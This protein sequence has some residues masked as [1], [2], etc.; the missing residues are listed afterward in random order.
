MFKQMK[1]GVKI[2]IGFACLLVIAIALGMLAISKMS[3]VK[4]E[5]TILSNEYVPEVK[6][7]NEVERFSL[8]TMYNMRGYAY[9]EDKNYL[10][11][12]RKN[13]ADVKKSITD[14]KALAE[15]A[16]HLVKLKSAVVEVDANVAEY[17]SL[18]NQTVD[19]NK[20][21]E[22]NRKQMDE[23]A[24]AYMQNCNEF[25]KMQ[26]DTMSQ[27]V[28]SELSQI[29]ERVQ[30][31]NLVNDIVDLG[32][33]IRLSVWRS[34]AEQNNELARQALNQFQEIDKK[35][36][37]LRKVTTQQVNLDQI[38]KTQ[39][40]GATYAK[41]IEQ[42][43]A[44]G[45]TD[46]VKK[47]LDESAK[48]YMTNCSN[49]LASQNQALQEGLN[50]L[51]SKLTERLTKITTVNDIIDL[52]NIT[53][54]A[55]WRAQAQ[56][57]PQ[58][59]QNAQ[60]NF[61]EMDKKFQALRAITRQQVNLQEIDATRTAAQ[62]YKDAMNALLVNWMAA[63]ELSVK[64]L[65]AGEAV[66]A[67]SQEIAMAGIEQTTAIAQQ[68]VESLSSATRSL[69][70]GLSAAV[71]LG[72]LIAVFITRMIVKPLQMGVQF[73]ELVAEGD[74]TQTIELN[75]KDEIGVL[76]NALNAM[77]AN[78]HNVMNQIQQ[79]AEQVAASSEE[80]SA[81]SQNMANSATEQAANLEETSAAIHQLN[82]SIGQNKESASNTDGVS[83]KAAIEAEQGGVAVEK[84][85]QAMKQIADKISI[86]ND[87]ADQTNLLALNA[88]IEAA[89]AGEMGKGF[90]VVAVEVRKLA[91]RSQQAAKEI[92]ELANN[93]VATAEEAGNLIKRVVPSIKNATQLVQEISMRCMEQAESSEQIRKA[94]DQL[95]QAT[96]SNSATSEEC[97][98]A[99]E[100]LSAQAIA[101]QELVSQFKLRN[102]NGSKQATRQA[103]KS[104]SRLDYG[105]ISKS[106]AALP[107][108]I[109]RASEQD[110]SE[111]T[112]E[113]RHF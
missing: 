94:M 24:A 19:T 58:V 26:N 88:A 91:E 78:L 54:I 60:P 107:A 57:D 74:L 16:S 48:T 3:G 44:S 45:A 65:A 102:N 73:A 36:E 68:T 40:A 69:I 76:A 67:K 83:S 21:I 20:T 81:S 13:L 90:A 96:Q 98:S 43:L 41:A 63:Q 15:S 33:A 99:S 104:V 111:T 108:S 12:G 14:A 31:I 101:L 113:F 47:Q 62:S 56:R 30:K 22:E 92:I 51:K 110:E 59:I 109:H 86:I 11:L 105:Y 28:D 103:A 32:N 49:F 52:G 66:L 53:R 10:D 70:V 50:Q 35:F 82:A 23:S 37:A 64:R 100:E 42:L 87:I 18:S 5:A 93:S 106:T 77:S 25:L 55:A 27:E 2:G 9:T 75:Q 80:L 79:S 1:L 34:Q 29:L 17:E 112:D 61:D 4:T 95:D 71:I 6:V 97:A 89:R 85:V 7:A 39:S 38:A 72:L 46:E 84:T 8:L